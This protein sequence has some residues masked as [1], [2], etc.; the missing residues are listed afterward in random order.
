M[1]RGDHE[2][3]AL[4]ETLQNRLRERSAFARFRA[5]SHL[6]HDHQRT[7]VLGSEDAGQIGH[8]RRK[9]GETR[10]QILLVADVRVDHVERRH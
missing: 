6:V 3:V 5:L 10:S 7:H 2:G 4:H 9:R 8:A 1:G